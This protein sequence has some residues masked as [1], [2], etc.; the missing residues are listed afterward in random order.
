MSKNLGTPGES[1][2]NLRYD[3]R[4]HTPK[5]LQQL[6]TYT[7]NTPFEHPQIGYFRTIA[8]LMAWMESPTNDE[9]YRTADGYDVVKITRSNR[10]RLV[11]NDITGARI[12]DSIFKF[13]LSNKHLSDLLK[14]TGN[15]KLTY[16]CLAKTEDVNTGRVLTYPD[17]RSNILE[18]SY[19]E[20]RDA[21]VE[22]REPDVSAVIPGFSVPV[23]Y[24]GLGTFVVSL[25]RETT[26]AEIDSNKPALL[27]RPKVD[28]PERKKP[29]SDDAPV[30][31]KKRPIKKKGY[32]NETDHLLGS[33]DNA[34]ALKESIAQLKAGDTKHHDLIY[35]DSVPSDETVSAMLEAR[36]MTTAYQGTPEELFAELDNK[37]RAPVA[38]STASGDAVSITQVPTDAAPV[39]E[40]KSEPESTGVLVDPAVA[41]E[42]LSSHF[43]R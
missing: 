7:H 21:L 3:N 20:I 28:M 31:K 42:A 35:P 1:H 25:R 12:A 27:K 30:M 8:G 40:E 34:A 41:F 18:K 43:G 33:A 23:S 38:E 39:S 9:V 16:Y 32:M 22:K 24:E 15:K 10:E 5:S 13:V 17:P 2:V 6:T 19:T 26:K 29:V 14:A 37:V 36:S 4:L 11:T